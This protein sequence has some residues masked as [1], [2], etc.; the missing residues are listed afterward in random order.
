[1]TE[2][3][4]QLGNR[5]APSPETIA[6]MSMNPTSPT[7]EAP[8]GSGSRQMGAPPPE[9][10][11]EITGEPKRSTAT[12]AV[13]DQPAEAQAA[14]PPRTKSPRPE[15]N[16]KLDRRFKFP[17]SPSPPVSG[18]TSTFPASSTE[19]EVV[20]P[21][22]VVQEKEKEEI[23]QPAALEKE[24]AEPEVESTSPSTEP[25]KITDEPKSTTG[26]NEAAGSPTA[27]TSQTGKA[28]ASESTGE[29][30]DLKTKAKEWMERQNT[31]ELDS[32]GHETKQAESI[33]QEEEEQTV[34]PSEVDAP[35]ASPTAAETIA[36][37]PVPQPASVSGDAEDETRATKHIVV[38][39]VT[40]ETVPISSGGDDKVESPDQVVPA[41]EP[42]QVTPAETGSKSEKKEIVDVLQDLDAEGGAELAKDEGDDGNVDEDEADTPAG[43]STPV[44]PSEVG[45]TE[46]AQGQTKSTGTG[47]KNKKKGKK[48]K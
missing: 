19:A 40:E 44:D 46:L 24:Q 21:T 22:E 5:R 13:P 8:S 14:S 11:K 6:R 47:K 28:S 33:A 37:E 3:A 42:Q 9:T 25:I 12:A 2:A 10:R 7:L 27:S 26:T 36:A 1:M 43:A 38:E 48:G 30:D 16:G 35:V 20:A 41:Q 15:A 18:S 31:V 17:N 34:K 39:D 32:A 4:E 29:E 23:V 45:T